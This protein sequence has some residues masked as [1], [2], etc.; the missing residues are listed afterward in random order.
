MTRVTLIK[1]L[2]KK[3]SKL[4]QTE[5]KLVID[6]FCESI[7]KALLSHKNIELRDFGTFFI[8]RMKEKFESRNPKTGE[9]IYVPEKNKVRFKA[10]KKLKKI[11]NNEKY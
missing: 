3:N 6:T 4:N 7:Q 9:I 5:I 10:S 2:K 1:E 11:I 8:K